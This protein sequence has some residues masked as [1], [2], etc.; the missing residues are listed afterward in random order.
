MSVSLVVHPHVHTHALTHVLTHVLTPVCTH[1]CTKTS[2][3][4][5][6]VAERANQFNP[7]HAVHREP[8]GDGGE[9]IVLKVF[10]AYQ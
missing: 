1:V 8:C 4:P 2:A 10:R 7:W 5:T 9:T 6:D 3:R